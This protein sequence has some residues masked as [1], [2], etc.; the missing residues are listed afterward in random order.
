ME[1]LRI[2]FNSEFKSDN[3]DDRSI[4]FYRINGVMTAVVIRTYY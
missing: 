4:G 1:I 2:S 3:Y